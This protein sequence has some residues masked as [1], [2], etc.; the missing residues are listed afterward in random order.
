[1]TV[2]FDVMSPQAA[3]TSGLALLAALFD[4]PSAAIRRTAQFTE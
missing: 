4:A 1:M 2:T 3:G